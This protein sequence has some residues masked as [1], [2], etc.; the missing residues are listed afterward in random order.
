LAVA[1]D[2]ES[3]T[4]YIRNITP[5]NQL[6]GGMNLIITADEGKVLSIWFEK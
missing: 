6:G 4:W 5:K 3:K 1:Y 2:A